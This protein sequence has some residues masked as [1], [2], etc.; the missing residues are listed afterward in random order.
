MVTAI[1]NIAFAYGAP[2]V[3]V[4]MDIIKPFLT[5][6]VKDVLGL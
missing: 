5:D 6:E 4:P 2:V 3:V 1:S